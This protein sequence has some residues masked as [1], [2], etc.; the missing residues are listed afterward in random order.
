MTRA[1]AKLGFLLGLQE[2]SGGAVPFERWMREALYHP[3]FGYY[4]ASIRGIG[5]GG[6]FTTWPLLHDSLARAVAAWALAHRPSRRWHV[7]EVGAGNGAF[8]E[9]VLKAIGWWNRP[10][11]HIV[12]VS[13][14]L[15]AQQQAR[16]K[17]KAVWHD[18]VQEALA[19]CAG[20]ALIFSNELVD[21]FPCRVFQRQGGDWK[22]LALRIEGGSVEEVWIGAATNHGPPRQGVPARAAGGLAGSVVFDH[23]WPE[24]QRVEVQESFAGWLREWMPSWKSGRMLTMD[25]GDFC[26]ALYERRP[27][28]SLRAY[29]HH[30]RIEG[31]EA[32]KGF[33][34]RDLTVD[35]NFSDVIRWTEAAGLRTGRCVSLAEFVASFPS[36]GDVLRALQSPGGAG[37]A[38][39]VLDQAR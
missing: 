15:R 17:A 16:L 32:F 1:E 10:Q 27:R 6:D 4:T 31:P 2:E 30:Q 21:A 34:M 13:P 23:D 24:G 11:Y 3:E 37:E 22:E 12:D 33:G 35:V 38:F 36:D 29:Q 39:K 14:V 28:G 9:G 20:E 18:S 5:R 8:A 7:I 19:A 25:Y 26:P